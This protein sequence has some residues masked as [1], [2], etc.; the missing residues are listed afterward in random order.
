[1]YIT[2]LPAAQDPE[3]PETDQKLS[4][5][6]TQEKQCYA[7]IKLPLN[8]ESVMKKIKENSTLVFI[9]DVKTNKHQIE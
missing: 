3:A 7:I 2:Y 9:V 1:M 8:T 6:L 5:E 4:K